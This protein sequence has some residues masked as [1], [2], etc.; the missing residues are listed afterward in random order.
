[1]LFLSTLTGATKEEFDPMK[2]LSDILVFDF[3]LI[4]IIIQIYLIFLLLITSL[5]ENKK[6]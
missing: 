1:M 3:F 6:T 4:Q 2:T 5:W